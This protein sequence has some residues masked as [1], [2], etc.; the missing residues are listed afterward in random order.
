M[1]NSIRKFSTSIF[2]K[3][4]LGIVVIPFVFWGMGSSFRGGSKNVVLKIDNEKYSTQ[5]FANFINS[6]K[7]YNEKVSSQKIDQL[8]AS[9]IGDKLLEKEYEYFD[10]TVSD[11]SLSK[12]IKNQKEFKKDN[13]FSRTEYEKF[14]VQN[15]IDAATFE[16]NLLIQE[17]KKQLLNFIGSGI[18][19][20]KFIINEIY[21]KINQERKI[22][23][24]NLNDIF[25]KEFNFSD[26]EIKNYYNNN[27]KEY[28]EIY[29]TAKVVELTPENIIGT[30][31]LNDIFFNKIDNIHDSILQGKKIKQ[32]INEYSLDKVNQ[33]TINKSG[34]DTNNKKYNNLPDILIKNIFLL[35]NEEPT[36]L[37]EVKDKFFIVEMTGIENVQKK[38]ENESVKIDIKKR[39]EKIKK[40]KL[41]SNLMSRINQNNFKKS[42]FNKISDEKNVRIQKINLKNI[43]DTT[44]LKNQVLN[45]IYS[46]PEKKIILSNDIN[47]SENF[48]IYIDKVN[49]VNIDENSEEYENY[50][51]LSKIN[52][53]GRLFNTY[54]EYIKKKYEIDINYKALKEV[55]NYFN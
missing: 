48:L 6:Q 3:I 54:D 29:K 32:I 53:S 42:D 22:E 28:N 26:D 50:F 40:R 33:F 2:A 47:L 13:K 12:L 35:T 37:I 18:V 41:I 23:L 7:K 34:H 30:D 31:E 55:K 16:S 52:I 43:N 14:L 1:L 21:N 38:I 11:L 20:N 5:E 24:I 10:V 45:H 36:N 15:N 44:I 8:L 27:K 9:F 51:K 4:L 17:K 49:N 25:A 39:L 46:T 19:P